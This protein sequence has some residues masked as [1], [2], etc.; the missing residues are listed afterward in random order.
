MNMIER[1]DSRRSILLFGIPTKTFFIWLNQVYW[2]SEKPS[3]KFDENIINKYIGF[4]LGHQ[5]TKILHL[6][7]H[8]P[9]L[10][11]LSG[12]RSQ[13]LRDINNEL[14]NAYNISIDSQYNDEY[15]WNCVNFKAE[16]QIT[17]LQ[18]RFCIFNANC[19]F[20]SWHHPLELH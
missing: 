17:F 11:F 4:L 8:L 20:R 15:P 19:I 12:H 5:M 7:S 9:G 6:E 13:I 14:M 2:N 3:P 1:C 18:I 10:L 16:Y